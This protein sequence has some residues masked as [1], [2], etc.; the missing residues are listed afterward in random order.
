M[1]NDSEFD[2]S[3]DKEKVS[4]FDLSKDN[5]DIKINIKEKQP[6]LFEV[7]QSFDYI[8]SEDGQ[9]DGIKGEYFARMVVFTNF[10]LGRKPIILIGPRSSGK[11]AI[12]AI[13]KK[14]ILAPTD[15]ALSSDMADYRD[16]ENLNKASH[17]FI[18]EINKVNDKFVEILKDMGEGVTSVY[19]F[20]DYDRIA[21]TIKINPKPFITSIATENRNTQRLGEEF[22]SRIT[23]VSTDASV[24]QNLRVIRHML[25]KAQNPYQE[26]KIPNKRIKKIIDYIKTLPSINDFVFI[27]LPG[28][29]VIQAIPP[30]FTDS[31]RDTQKYI[32]NTNGIALFH[33]NER[34]VVDYKKK[35]NVLV[36]P[37][38]AWYNHRIYNEILVQ[39]SLKLGPL[40]RSIIN[41]IR[42]ETELLSAIEIRNKVLK[43]KIMASNEVVKKTCDN[44][45]EIGYLTKIEDQRPF[46]YTLN[47]VLE[48]D[49]RG[50]IDWKEVLDECIRAVKEEFPEYAKEYINRFCVNP[51]VID[52]FTGNKISILDQK[53]EIKK[54]LTVPICEPSVH[55]ISDSK[56]DDIEILRD[57]ILEI[58]KKQ[59]DIMFEDLFEE[60]KTELN[61]DEEIV[62]QEVNYLKSMGELLYNRGKIKVLE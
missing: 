30:I 48:D 41:I 11:T 47:S 2:L 15:I 54:E 53:P 26:Q 49:Y 31:R 43:K 58:A 38:D 3:K 18:P 40:E 23:K 13:C 55:I 37:A 7:N 35:K 8:K 10:V 12:I 61:Y 44:L 21:R 36:T 19:K 46:K 45:T 56:K 50:W 6:S 24:D 57:K 34:I 25:Y 16:F 52:P 33:I 29:S 27:Y 22:M 17:F 39:S 51:V 60:L 59:D 1:T 9:H 20:T 28:K 14:F 32:A 62:E 42:S 4:K 5:S